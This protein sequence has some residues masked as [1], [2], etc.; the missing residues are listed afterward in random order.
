MMIGDEVFA[1]LIRFVH[2]RYKDVMSISKLQLCY[3]L[4]YNTIKIPHN[5]L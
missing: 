4:Y 5:Y 1:Q 3:I 2:E